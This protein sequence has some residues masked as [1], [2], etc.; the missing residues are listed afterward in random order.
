[1]TVAIGA[2][3]NPGTGTEFFTIR[4]ADSRSTATAS[5]TFTLKDADGTFQVPSAPGTAIT[6]AGRD[7]K[8]LIAGYDMGGQHLVYSTSELMTHT[9]TGTG[10]VAVFYGR[11]GQ[12]GETVLRYSSQPTVRVLAGSVAATWDASTGDLRLDYTHGSLARVQISGGGR[13]G[14]LLLIG[15]DA[16]VSTIWRMVTTSGPLLVAVPS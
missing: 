8:L 6:L 5:T 9:S 7:S 14:L 11:T 13:S 4:Q 12:A 15:D 3:V 10:D 16:A 1:V 2:R